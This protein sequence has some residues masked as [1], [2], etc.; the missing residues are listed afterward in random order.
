MTGRLATSIAA[1]A[2]I[3]I[4]SP[5][6]CGQTKYPQPTVPMV[7]HSSP[8]GGS[9]VFVREPVR[10]LG[11]VIGVTLVVENRPGGSG[12]KA[13]AKVAQ[14]HADGSV[15]YV[16]TPTY[17]QTTLLS[18]LD[19][20]YDSLDPLVTI[21]R[22]HEILYTRTQSPFKTLGRRQLREAKRQGKVGCGQSDIARADSA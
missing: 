21:F 7:T 17:I 4:L 22:D 3:A 18:K 19:F 1:L 10:H 6:V 16:T 20:G 15:F 11:P 9:Y 13:I 2:A 12:A 14:A 5:A 8:G